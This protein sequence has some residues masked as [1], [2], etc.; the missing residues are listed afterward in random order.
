MSALKPQLSYHNHNTYESEE[1]CIQEKKHKIYT[2]HVVD[3]ISKY[4]FYNFDMHDA[5]A[6]S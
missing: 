4:S 2:F 6:C 5:L 1:R 3:A